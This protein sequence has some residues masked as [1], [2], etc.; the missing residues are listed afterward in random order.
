M[1]RGRDLDLSTEIAANGEDVT[2]A[3]RMAHCG[4]LTYHDE[5]GDALHV[6]RYGRVPSGNI[7]GLDEAMQADLA[8][9]PSCVLD[10][11]SASSC[12]PTVPRR[13]GPT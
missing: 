13:Y 3:F 12:S 9:P 11:T 7:G 1:L 10:P 8:T 4:T 6:T 2:R 5:E